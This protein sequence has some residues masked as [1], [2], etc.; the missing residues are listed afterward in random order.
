[1]G[2]QGRAVIWRENGVA[3][4]TILE[5]IWE[6]SIELIQELGGFWSRPFVTTGDPYKIDGAIVGLNPATPICTE[7]RKEKFY[8]L[9]RNRREFE[10]WYKE[11][12]RNRGQNELST[13]RRR[14]GLI[15]DCIPEL[16]FTETN[17]NA[18]PT[19]DGD[20][21]R[22]SPYREKGAEIAR[23]YLRQIQPKV[24]IIHHCDALNALQDADYVTLGEQSQ[25]INLGEQF[26]QIK[27]Y[28]KHHVDA[29]WNG[30]PTL[31]F[32]IPGLAARRPK[33]WTDNAIRE[34][35]TEIANIV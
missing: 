3:I 25:Q 31:A 21:L 33:G 28:T 18:L 12:R 4:V 10:K 2:R 35:A 9:I 8:R 7:L 16:N 23:A 6:M 17:V 19:K 26:Q 24:V 22:C 11:L 32:S 1:M 13:T 34:I 5:F 14:L 15:I 29:R 27:S 20:E 30:K